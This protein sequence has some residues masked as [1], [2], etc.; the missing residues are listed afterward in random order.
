MKQ[1]SEFCPFCGSTNKSKVVQKPEVS[2]PD[3]KWLETYDKIKQNEAVHY[4]DKDFNSPYTYRNQANTFKSMNAYTDYSN[5]PSYVGCSSVFEFILE[6]LDV[7]FF[8]CGCFPLMMVSVFFVSL[9]F[10]ITLKCN[11]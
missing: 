1:G 9:L 8:G 2:T 6:F 3:A 10:L 5:T 7:V 4:D 11:L